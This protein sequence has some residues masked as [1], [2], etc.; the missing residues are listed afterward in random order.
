MAYFES[1]SFFLANL[2][3]C[4]N[5]L[6]ISLG[7]GTYFTKFGNIADNS[8][9][10]CIYKGERANAEYKALSGCNASVPLDV[11]SCG[12]FSEYCFPSELMGPVANVSA[13]DTVSRLTI[14]ALEDVGYNVNYDAAGEYS[15]K[16][17]NAN[18]TCDPGRRSVLQAETDNS[19]QKRGRIRK[20]TY[21]YAHAYGLDFLA[22]RN[23]RTRSLFSFAFRGGMD[24]F[25]P[26]VSVLVED[27]DGIHGVL[28]KAPQP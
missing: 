25:I 14:A 10:A 16:D 22:Q 6:S 1:D 3:S 26:M 18:C 21:E 13:R 24:M 17:I 20:E 19:F 7:L 28:V 12:H 15:R 23:R 4:Y 11:A 5:F 27:K 9:G 2:F 8:T